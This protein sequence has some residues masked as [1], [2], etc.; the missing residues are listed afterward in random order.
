MVLATLAAGRSDT[1]LATNFLVGDSVTE[2]VTEKMGG[3]GCVGGS[4]PKLHSEATCICSQVRV[5][6]WPVVQD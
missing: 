6:A 4:T 2:S 5:V 1:P 3:W